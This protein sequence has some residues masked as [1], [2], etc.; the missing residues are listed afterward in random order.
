M[1]ADIRWQGTIPSDLE[2]AE[3]EEKR[4]GLR[5]MKA[6]VALGEADVVGPHVW[7]RIRDFKS[8]IRTDKAAD[9]V[10]GVQFSS[11][12]TGGGGP[13]PQALLANF[14][15]QE[16][17]TAKGQNHVAGENRVTDA[18]VVIQEMVSSAAPTA[19]AVSLSPIR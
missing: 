9:S 10:G 13:G 3:E 11:S 7:D 6:R 19:H 2:E 14:G 4:E 15:S 16:R 8:D 17:S 18:D 5:L 12:A 1:L